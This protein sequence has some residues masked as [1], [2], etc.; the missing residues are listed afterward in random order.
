M[1]THPVSVAGP[2]AQPHTGLGTASKAIVHPP[3]HRG[4]APSEEQSCP[5][6]PAGRHP[7]ELRA[8]GSRGTT[9][10]G[11]STPPAQPLTPQLPGWWRGRAAAPPPR[12]PGRTQQAWHSGGSAGARVPL[13]GFPIS[14]S[15]GP[16]TEA[17]AGASPQ[18]VRDACSA[19]LGPGVWPSAP[20][21]GDRVPQW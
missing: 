19:A 16:Q 11:L 5:L 12:G 7:S 17:A 13:L 9:C 21:T 3:C 18:R 2:S 4:P 6:C 1:Q 15:R 14:V 8:R 20:R 10:P